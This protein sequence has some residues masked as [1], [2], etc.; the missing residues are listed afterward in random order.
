MTAKYTPG[1]WILHVQKDGGEWDYTIRTSA[2]HNPNGKIGKHV[3]TLNQHLRLDDHYSP[4]VEGNGALIATA[5][6]MFEALHA[7]LFQLTQG[8][9]VFARDAC[10]TQARAAYLKANGTESES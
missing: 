1:P 6:E 4:A 8:E 5:P 7:I 3:A 10:I 9:K 2:P